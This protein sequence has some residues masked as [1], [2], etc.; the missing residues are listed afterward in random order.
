MKPFPSL[1]V[2][3]LFGLAMHLTAGS[4]LAQSELNGA[5]KVVEMSGKN[6]DGNYKITNIQPSLLIFHDGY[7]SLMID[8]GDEK[9]PTYGDGESRSNVDAEKLRAIISPLQ[10]N[11]GVYEIS[12]SKIISKAMVAINP[13]V[14]N[15]SENTREFWFEND[16][17]Y[18]LGTFGADGQHSIQ[19]TLERLK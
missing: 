14:E 17:L 1:F 16:K 4:V 13:N 12:G 8:H 6:A 9:R 2:A 10:M 11:S 15:Y 3:M 7:Y 18:L 19:M 5:W